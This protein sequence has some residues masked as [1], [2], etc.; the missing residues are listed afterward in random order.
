MVAIAATIYAGRTES[1]RYRFIARLAVAW[2][3]V[4]LAVLVPVVLLRP[5]LLKVRYVMFVLPG[6]AILGGLGLVIVMGLV[7]QGLARLAGRTHPHG[8]Q[9]RGRIITA[10]AYGIGVLAVA[11]VV[12]SQVETLR[13][14]RTPGGHGE[15][16]RPA[17]AS[18]NR[19]EYANLPIVVSPPNNAL[20]VA[21]YAAEAED[22]L[23]GLNVQRDQPSIW[24]RTDPTANGSHLRPGQ[25][26]VLLMRAPTT[27]RCRWSSKPAAEAAAH[28]THCLPESFKGGAYQVE[29]AEAR[30]RRWTFAIL[31]YRPP[32]Q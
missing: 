7:R 13:A 14:I 6:W 21:A 28:V 5:N 15:D 24:P 18:A 27:G 26:V 1:P 30:G 32:Y 31:A 17:L 25:R 8:G 9:S 2:A 20:E 4:P 29:Y 11:G 23:T 16:I 22:R 19:M 10:A 12:A 3:V